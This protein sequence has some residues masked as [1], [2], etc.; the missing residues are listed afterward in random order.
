MSTL[1]ISA[2]RLGDAIALISV[3]M[4]VI[5]YVLFVFVEK[6]GP[7]FLPM[8]SDTFVP[9]PGNFLSRGVLSLTGAA[10]ALL[11]AVPYYSPTQPSECISRSVLFWM[12]A[13]AAFNLGIVGAVC[14]STDVPS[15]MGNT[16]IHDATAVTFFVLYDVYMGTLLARDLRGATCPSTRFVLRAAFVLSVVSKVRFLPPSALGAL[17][18]PAGSASAATAST[19][20]A[21]VATEARLASLLASSSGAALAVFE[22]LDVLSIMAFIATYSA[23]MGKSFFYG[24][25]RTPP[26]AKPGATAPE[27]DSASPSV[28]PLT[29]HRSI[30]VAT[31]AKGAIAFAVGTIGYTFVVALH[32]GVIHPLEEW[33]M[34]S[35][36]W[37]HKPSNMISRY[38]VCLGGWLLA[39]AQVG[40]YAAVRPNRASSPRLNFIGCVCGVVSAI[41]LVGVGACNERENKPVHYT[42]AMTF[43]GCFALWAL[44]D[45]K[46]SARY[47][48]GGRRALAVVSL[49]VLLAAKL[50]Q[51]SHLL[52]HGDLRRSHDDLVVLSFSHPQGLAYVEW[53]GAG[54]GMSYFYLANSSLPETKLTSLAFYSTSSAAAMRPDKQAQLKA[55]EAAP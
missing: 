21:A 36:L 32:D 23:H 33:P 13:V 6:L 34:I 25:V 37:V 52:K 38:T 7:A 39:V 1:A 42:S 50:A 4:L 5:D 18:R 16:Q 19:A 43:F 3:S 22:Y 47:W 54:A 35:D 17:L 24:L 20:A 15:C 9:Q 48:I 55:A 26:A 29:V 10:L 8:L 28:A 40:H 31:L 2:A 41:G 45:L 51:L 12:S 30:S 14:E 11:G 44:I 49:A 27:P 46:T 53:L